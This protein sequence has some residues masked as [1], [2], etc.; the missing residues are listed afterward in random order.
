MNVEL[1][2][3]QWQCAS[4]INRKVLQAAA[5]VS[6][7]PDFNLLIRHACKTFHSKATNSNQLNFQ[8]A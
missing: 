8:S 6:D 1:Q 4:G 3:A 7:S 2:A 5:T